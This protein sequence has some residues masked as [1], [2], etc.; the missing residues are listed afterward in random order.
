MRIIN[1]IAFNYLSFGWQALFHWI[2]FNWCGH[3]MKWYRGR[4]GR[5]SM[6]SLPLHP[7]ILQATC[8]RALM[9]SSYYS[10]EGSEEGKKDESSTVTYWQLLNI[11]N[12]I[13]HFLFSS[14]NEMY[15]SQ[16]LILNWFEDISC[17]IISINVNSYRYYRKTKIIRW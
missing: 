12:I 9:T 10:I 11:R 5:Q 4:W 2:D 14:F 16:C 13:I 1:I 17:N 3:L 7:G 15:M 8:L 6:H